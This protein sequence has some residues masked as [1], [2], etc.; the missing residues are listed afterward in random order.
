MGTLVKTGH[1]LIFR[2]RNELT[3]KRRIKEAIKAIAGVTGVPQQVERIS[4]KIYHVDRGTQLLLAI[5]YKDLKERGTILRFDDVE[6][7]NYSQNGEDGILLYVFS[8]IGTIN[9]KCIEICAGDG[10]QCN[11]A[12]LIINHGWTGLLFDGDPGHVSHGQRFYKN[13][14]DTFT[15]P[16]RFVKAWITAEHVNELIASNGFTGEVDLLSLDIDGMDYWVWK[17]IEV[18]SPRVVIAEI[19]AIWGSETSVTV[20]YRPDFKAEYVHGYGIYSGASLPAFVKL[21]KLKGYRLVGCQRYGFNVV[22]LRNDVGQDILP[23]IPA[24]QC[25]FHPFAK[26]AYDKLRPLVAG[27]EWQE[28]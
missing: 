16:P 1:R 17:A 24:D 7:R 22:F 12:N 4:R 3:P 8:L 21:G 6:F 5:K 2:R 20:P 14:P 18:I 13:H 11:C 25:F 19:Q 28:V 26:M 23:E 10:L 15:Y 9:K 27:R